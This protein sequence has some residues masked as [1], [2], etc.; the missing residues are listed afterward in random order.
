MIENVLVRCDYFSG[1]GFGHYQRS[2][3]LACSFQCDPSHIIIFLDA[4]DFKVKT[5]RARLQETGLHSWQDEIG[6]A[7][8]IKSF[9]TSPEKCLVILD[10][11][12]LGDNWISCIQDSGTCVLSINDIDR[13]SQANIILDYRP[14]RKK[15]FINENTLYLNGVDYFLTRYRKP[16]NRGHRRGVICHA[17]GSGL[18]TRAPHI[19]RTASL[20]ASQFGL[21][22]DWLVPD[23]KTLSYL[24][25]KHLIQSDHRVIT[26]SNSD[27]SVWEGYRYV[28]GPSSTSVYESIIANAIPIS[29][30]ISDTQ[31]TGLNDWIRIGHCLHIGHDDLHDLG[32]IENM[33]SFAFRHELPLLREQEE[34]SSSLDG[35]GSLRVK[36]LTESFMNGSQLLDIQNSVCD[37][38]IRCTLAHSNDYLHARNSPDVRRLSGSS[39]VITWSEHLKWWIREDIQQYAYYVHSVP[40]A[41]LWHKNVDIDGQS[42]ITAGWFPASSQTSFLDLSKAVISHITRVDALTPDAIWVASIHPDNKAAQMLNKRAGFRMVQ[43]SQMLRVSRIILSSTPDS[44]LFMVRIP[45]D[46]MFASN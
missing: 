13:I 37:G 6:D 31:I 41:Y 46:S 32:I 28:I 35:K 23:K 42:F 18:F 8:L 4:I 45:S 20:L 33:M 19:Y 40:V 2:L 5:N 39:A 26:W 44:Y 36:H 3:Q 22:L 7:Q 27:V 29:F 16:I 1:S 9:I 14:T 34:A 11:Y 30:P 15:S 12:R 21:T 10:S 38:L 24:K 17:G 25:Q 43:S